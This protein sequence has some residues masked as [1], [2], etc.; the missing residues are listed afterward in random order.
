MV[1]RSVDMACHPA[2]KGQVPISMCSHSDLRVTRVAYVLPLFWPVVRFGFLGYSFL[3][4]SAQTWA[5]MCKHRS[6]RGTRLSSLRSLYLM[7]HTQTNSIELGNSSAVRKALA[8]LCSDESADVR[9]ACF[10]FGSRVGSAKDDACIVGGRA[11]TCGTR[12]A[13][14]PPCAAHRAALESE[15]ASSHVRCRA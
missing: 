10:R 1:R 8:P 3:R 4:P 14:E 7:E 9:C 13:G 12:G 11:Q 6:L 2:G 15:C 5:P